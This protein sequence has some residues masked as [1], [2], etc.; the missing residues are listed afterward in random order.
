VAVGLSDLFASNALVRW[1]RGDPARYDLLTRMVGA[2]LGDRLLSFGAGDPG[3]V[4]AVARVTGLSGRAVAHAASAEESA[5]LVSTA[6]AAGVLVEVVESPGTRLTFKEGDF[7]LVLVDVVSAPFAVL[8]PEIRRVLRPGG[9]VVLVVRRKEAGAPAPAAV[10]AATSAHF[11]GARVLF[12]RDGFG[13]V[14]ALK[15]QPSST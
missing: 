12:D 15:G 8:L 6:E 5:R 11:R 4:A 7:D 13:I 10:Q 3:L 9:R 14:E 1:L 2:R